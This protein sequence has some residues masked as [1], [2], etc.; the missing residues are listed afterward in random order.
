ME[1]MRRY[2]TEE[3]QSR[4]LKT[5]GQYAGPIPR[6]DG[7]CMRLLAGTGMRLNELVTCTVG[8]A[9]AA[10]ENGYLFVPREHHAQPR[11]I[12]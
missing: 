1:V 5:V 12:A 8:D 4:L 9:M 2:L 6:R 3:E 11:P 7:A 10:L